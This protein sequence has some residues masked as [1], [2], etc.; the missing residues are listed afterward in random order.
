MSITSLRKKIDQIDEKMVNLLNERA[1]LSKSI[2]EK[3]IEKNKSIYAPHR[4]K[5]IFLRLRQLNKGPLTNDALESVYRE[6]MSGS[7][8]LEKPIK[9]AYLG[10]EGSYTH[11][12]ANK[13]FGSQV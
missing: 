8:S 1:K 10:T 9:I 11:L 13:K 7:L 2:G 5:E 4:E 6:I 12:A 3:K